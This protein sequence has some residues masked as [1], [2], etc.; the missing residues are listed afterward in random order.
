MTR[1]GS[2]AL[3]DGVVDAATI[4]IGLAIVVAKIGWRWKIG[5]SPAVSVPMCG[6]DFLNGTVVLPFVLML[7]SVFSPV[8]FAYLKSA[9]PVMTAIAGGIGL[10]FVLGELSRTE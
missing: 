3:M 6:V 1:P 10:F 4:G 2:P 9:N 5:K 7:G 8:V